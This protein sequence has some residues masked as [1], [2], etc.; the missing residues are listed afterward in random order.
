M[1]LARISPPL[2]IFEDFE[3]CDDDQGY[4]RLYFRTGASGNCMF[5]RSGELLQGGEAKD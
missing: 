2:N 1:R 3:R 4:N 5:L